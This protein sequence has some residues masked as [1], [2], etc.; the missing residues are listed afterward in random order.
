ML[1]TVVFNPVKQEE[2]SSSGRWISLRRGRGRRRR[3]KRWAIRS[4]S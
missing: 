1:T 2:R 4:T 3:R